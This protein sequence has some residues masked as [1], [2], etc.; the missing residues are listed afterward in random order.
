MSTRV[1]ALPILAWA[2]L[3]GCG[4]AAAQTA[5]QEAP[6]RLADTGLYADFAAGTIARDA[7]PFEPQY[8]LWTDGAAKRRW[9]H[10]PAGTAIDASDPDAWVFPAGTKLWKEF[11]L[12]RRVETRYLEKR[13]DGSWLRAA[14]VW[15]EDGSE[16]LLAPAAGVRG[17][18]EVAPG[19]PYDVPGRL[20]CATCHAKGDGV[21][22][23]GALQLSPDR[24]P[25]APHARAEVP[26]GQD[27]AAFVARGQVRGLPEEL[28]R[29]P[30][31][32]EARTPRERAALGYLSTHCGSC[33]WD[34]G[35]LAGLDMTLDARVDAGAERALASLLDRVSRFQPPAMPGAPA[36]DAVRLRPGAPEES[37]LIYRMTT[38][39]PLA[40][41]PPLGTHV[42]DSEARDLLEAWIREDLTV[43][44]D[45]VSN[46]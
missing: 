9:I 43:P 5:G 15:S 13:A 38:R 8:P 4:P 40:Q 36:Q 22:G 7:W 31:R 45:L 19:V 39:E 21:L 1:L 14:Y 16:A 37:V 46:L 25:L 17:A 24:D 3:A 10:V 20:D 12:E 18:A 33:H 6:A 23:F 26:P 2:A 27:L 28:L 41:M 29:V 30:P 34:G 11:A 42:V 35:L 44:R 32:V